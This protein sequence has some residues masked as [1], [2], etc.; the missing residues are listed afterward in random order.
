MTTPLLGDSAA[1]LPRAPTPALVKYRFLT[2][3]DTVDQRTLEA[4]SSPGRIASVGGIAA[5][6]G[7]LAAWV[8][9]RGSPVGR[10]STGI[11]ATGGRV[12]G[13]AWRMR[14]LFVVARYLLLALK[15]P[16]SEKLGP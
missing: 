5:I 11:V 7:I 10:R 13:A 4:R 1:E 12:I 14:G 16:R 2:W 8:L 15:R 3:A 6:G 9:K